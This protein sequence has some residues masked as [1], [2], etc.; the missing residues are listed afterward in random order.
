MFSLCYERCFFEVKCSFR[1]MFERRGI[2]LGGGRRKRNG[3]FESCEM[4]REWFF[5][6][7]DMSE[8]KME[9]GLVGWS[10]FS[11]AHSK[12][13]HFQSQKRR[14]IK[15][16]NTSFTKTLLLL[17][18]FL[19]FN[20]LMYILRRIFCTCSKKRVWKFSTSFLT[21]VFR[22]LT[23]WATWW[24]HFLRRPLPA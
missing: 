20:N 23:F 8:T 6:T 19:S 7:F 4:L 12:L 3:I 22:I 11:S 15:R 17:L 13:I 18:L 9:R 21:T 5:T 14:K 24:I 10:I 2:S 1:I 16:T